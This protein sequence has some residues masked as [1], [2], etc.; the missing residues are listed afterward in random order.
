MGF[1]TDL[2]FGQKYEKKFNDEYL[3][4]KGVLSKGVFLQYDI[5]TEKTYEVKADRMAGNTGNFFIEYKCRDKP[6]GITTSTADYWVLYNVGSNDDC[7]IVPTKE[8]KR[9]IKKKEYF[10]KVSG[11]D[12][13]KSKGYLI[14]VSSFEDFLSK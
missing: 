8:I 13:W 11:G 3:E 2:D 1:K 7:Y 9:I 14:K 5:Q 12:G 6:S 4:G 10:K